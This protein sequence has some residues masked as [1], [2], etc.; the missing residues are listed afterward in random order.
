MDMISAQTGFSYRLSR[1]TD[2]AARIIE[3]LTGRS[4]KVL[5][6]SEIDVYPAN[7]TIVAECKGRYDDTE[8]CFLGTGTNK[9]SAI[10]EM[11]RKMK[12]YTGN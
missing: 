3:R 2:P 6:T 7:R 12:V 9:K 4:G 8:I 5:R 10:K 1:R 11:Y